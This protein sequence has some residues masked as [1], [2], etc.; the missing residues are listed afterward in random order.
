MPG[1]GTYVKALT[2]GAAL[3]IGG[4]ALVWYITPSEEEI[5]KR[6]NPE[7]QKR[8]LETREARQQEFD[9]FVSQLKEA[10]KSDKPIWFA[11]KEIQQRL[12]N[13]KTQRLREEQAQQQAEAEKRRAEIRS[14]A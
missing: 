6:Y 1:A 14:S 7:L 13:E 5:F 10:S 3:C 11:Q 8:A 2:A 12:A 4:P 9:D